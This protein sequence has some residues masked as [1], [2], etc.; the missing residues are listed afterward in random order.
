MR[1][2]A[3]ALP[4]QPLLSWLL[5]NFNEHVTNHVDPS[6][7]W[8]QL[9]ARRVELP[10][11]FSANQDVASLWQAVWQQRRGPVLCARPVTP[12]EKEAS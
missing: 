3:R 6:I 7:P 12:R 4:R 9:P 11:R 8:Y 5:L 2:N 1:Y 10:A